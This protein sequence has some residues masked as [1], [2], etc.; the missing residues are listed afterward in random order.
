[1]SLKQT[2][3][4]KVVQ[5][6]QITEP[7]LWTPAG[8]SESDPC[9]QSPVTNPVSTVIPG[10]YILLSI[11]L[12]NWHLSVTSTVP[13]ITLISQGELR[14]SLKKKNNPHPKLSRVYIYYSMPP[15]N[16]TIFTLHFPK[17]LRLNEA[18]SCLLQSS[19]QISDLKRGVYNS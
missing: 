18:H 15:H 19:T 4:W 9:F 17:R 1:M 5:W 11:P 7:G 10:F 16:T 14:R 12:F 2:P 6:I 8:R 3:Y 13:G